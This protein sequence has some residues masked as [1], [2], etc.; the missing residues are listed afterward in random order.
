MTADDLGDPLHYSAEEVEESQGQPRTAPLDWE[1]FFAADFGDV[2][3]LPG[4][5]MASGQQIALVGD[6][7]VGKSLFSL[8]WAWRMAAGMPFLG[9]IARPPV[10]VLYI[11]AENG[12]P[13]LQDRLRSL[14]AAP[15]T[16]TNLIYYSFPPLPPLDTPAGGATLMAVVEQHRAD[17]VF[18]DTVSRFISGKE[19]EPDTWLAVYRCTLAHL[20]AARVGSVRL[21][22][23]G[24]DKERGARGGSTKSQDVDHVWELTGSGN[25]LLLNRTHTRTGLGEGRY[26][27]LRQGTKEAGRWKAGATRHVLAIERGSVE[28]IAARLDKAE[29]PTDWGRDK[30]KKKLIEMGVPASNEKI[31]EALRIR[32]T[33]TS[34]L[35]ATPGTGPKTNLSATPGTGNDV[36]ADQT[37]PGQVSKTPGQPPT[38]PVRLSPPLKRGTGDR[39]GSLGYPVGECAE[40]GFPM[41][42]LQPGQTVHPLCVPKESS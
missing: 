37:C 25:T 31:S 27:V 8:E 26:A 28:D 18:L 15:A 2:D 17:I 24:K 30:V 16:L 1:T 32:K 3:W 12:W 41:A 9:D 42:I 40:C 5:L 11:D 20:K 29:I 34:D 23:F 7:K 14:G 22:H 13:D 21:D 10:R 33:R 35:S 38:T 39:L 6:G 4:K 19:S 36:S